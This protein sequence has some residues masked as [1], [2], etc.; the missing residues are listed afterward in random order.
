MIQLINEDGTLL[1]PPVNP[2]QEKWDQAVPNCGINYK[3]MYC[4]NKQCYHSADWECPEED[5]E[6]YEQHKEELSQYIQQHNPEFT[7]EKGDVNCDN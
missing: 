5:K 3:C 7:S 6:V 4:D 2:L 1:E